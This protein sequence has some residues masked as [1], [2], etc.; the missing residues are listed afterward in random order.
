VQLRLC[1]TESASILIR[2]DRT[3]YLPKTL[4]HAVDLPAD[5]DVG[6]D[7][8]QELGITSK[9]RELFPEIFMGTINGATLM[10]WLPVTIILLGNMNPALVNNRPPSV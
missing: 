1:L 2:L 4:H 5:L 6:E 9:I 3:E 10:Q 8:P 7:I